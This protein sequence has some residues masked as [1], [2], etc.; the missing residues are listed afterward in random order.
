MCTDGVPPPRRFGTLIPTP[1]RR[2]LA[3][4]G[5][6]DE[7]QRALGGATSVGVSGFNFGALSATGADGIERLNG[8]WCTC[9]CFGSRAGVPNT[10]EAGGGQAA[11]PKRNT[12]RPPSTASAAASA[13]PSDVAAPAVAALVML[14]RRSQAGPSSGRVTSSRRR[15][16]ASAH[17][18]GRPNSNK[19]LTNRAH[20][21]PGKMNSPPPSTASWRAMGVCT[22]PAGSRAYTTPAPT[23]SASSSE[24][25]PVGGTARS[26]A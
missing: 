14:Q 11:S 15:R 13:M 25:R 22:L 23:A 24:I 1:A 3:R 10:C 20:A 2:A 9:C 7:G 8:G 5:R 12:V 18:R 16:R 17:A 19:F 6:Q 4:G 21:P 26:H